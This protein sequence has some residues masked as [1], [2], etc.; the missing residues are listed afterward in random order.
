MTSVLYDVPGPKAIARR[1]LL[2]GDRAP[3][4]DRVRELE[5]P[6]FNPEQRDALAQVLAADEL[7]MVHGPPGTGKTT[8]LI[9]AIARLVAQRQAAKGFVSA[10]KRQSNDIG[11]V[12]LQAQID[13]RTNKA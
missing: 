10:V 12:D 2:L 1:A 5:H 7:A 8:V 6:S 13:A 9:E 3:R 11:D 4:A